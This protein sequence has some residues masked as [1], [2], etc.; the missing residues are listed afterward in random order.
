MLALIFG[1]PAA[2][3][4]A[5]D[6]IRAIHRRVHGRLP[7]DAG[8]FAAGTCYSAEDPELVL[9]VHATLLESVP[10]IYE[11]LVGPLTAG[12]RDEYCADGAPVAIALGA[13][14]EDV[15]RTWAEAARY[16]ESMHASG[17]LTVTPQARE[18]ARAV[19][20]PGYAALVAPAARANRLLTLGLL[21]SSIRAQ[22]GFEWSPR[23]ARA[24]R[25]TVRT[26]RLARRYAP[27]FLAWWA[28][29]RSA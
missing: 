20:T 8:P 10:M 14:P 3:Q 22:F 9:W 15:P 2:H 13:R 26:L 12:E 17:R 6:G 1:D 24:L 25:T 28:S 5:L 16:L 21:P 23:D 29:A 19:L 27:P 4:Q 18:I 7:I 11:T